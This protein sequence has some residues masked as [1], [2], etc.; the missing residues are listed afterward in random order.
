[1]FTRISTLAFMVSI[2]VS[3]A[4][5]ASA[6]GAYAIG[7]S[8]HGSWGGGAGNAANPND[9][10]RDA[11]A[12]C[13]QHGPG[14]TI[15]TNFSRACFSLAIPLGTNGYYWATRETLA[16]AQ[17]IVMDH[18][19]ASGR[20]CEIK[21]AFCDVR[22]I[23][24][25]PSYPS[26]PVSPAVRSAPVEPQLILLLIPGILLAIGLFIMFGMGCFGAPTSKKSVQRRDDSVEG[27]DIAM[28][29]PERFDREAAAIRALTRATE[30]ET[31]LKRSQV[32][33]ARAWAEYEEL[34]DLIKHDKQARQ[35]KSPP[36][37]R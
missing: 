34:E 16:D 7:R 29:E 23:A 21:S 35:L 12:R 33:N 6:A 13:G 1:M 14:C 37:G 28:P 5:D 31:S 15:V 10:A 4:E 20:P 26:P 22:G 3:S 8:E 32:E 18:C 2:L 19:L 17:K 24:V 9:A 25:A 36:A 27:L 30:A 11:L